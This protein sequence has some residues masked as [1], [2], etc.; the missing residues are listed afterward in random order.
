MG[1]I[2]LRPHPLVDK[3]GVIVVT[4]NSLLGI[5]GFLAH[6]ALDAEGHLNANYGLMDRQYRV[7]RA[8]SARGPPRCALSSNRPSGHLEDPDNANPGG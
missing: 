5:L 8:P 3:G 7:R 6:P 2:I 1:W 4:L